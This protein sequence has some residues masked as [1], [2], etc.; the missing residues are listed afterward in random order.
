MINSLE[1]KT[2]KELV[3]ICKIQ[4]EEYQQLRKQFNYV[5]DLYESRIENMETRIKEL[6]QAQ[7][8]MTFTLKHNVSDEIRTV[9]LIHT[10]IQEELSDFIIESLSPNCACIGSYCD[11]Y[12]YLEGFELQP[13]QPEVK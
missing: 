7:Q 12:D 8:V 4:V 10:E 5:V 13:Q 9:T 2:K 3:E 11:C 6:E 1:D